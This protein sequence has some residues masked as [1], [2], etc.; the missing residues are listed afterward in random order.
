MLNAPVAV[1]N[2]KTAEVCV[3]GLA[4]M[5]LVTFFGVVILQEIKNR[6]KK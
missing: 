4:I 6:K 1:D 5:F 3:F 2:K